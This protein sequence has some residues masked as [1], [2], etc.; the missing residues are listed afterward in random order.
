MSCFQ[1]L[2]YFSCDILLWGWTEFKTQNMTLWP[3]IRKDVLSGLI[4]YV[5]N[6]KFSLVF[7]C[8][9]FKW[10]YIAISNIWIEPISVVHWTNKDFG[11]YIAFPLPT[12]PFKSAIK[13]LLEF[14]RKIITHYRKWVAD[15][16]KNEF[17]EMQ[18]A[19]LLNVGGKIIKFS[20][21]SGISFGAVDA[22][23]VLPQSLR[24]AL[25]A[26]KFKHQKI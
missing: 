21:V 7:Q 14:R 2:W 22:P 3:V 19:V 23:R 8:I 16:N 13:N 20:D 18:K 6:L 5:D 1:L 11:R 9:F 4:K 15:D 12:L 24:L 26:K 17:D 10:V 25:H